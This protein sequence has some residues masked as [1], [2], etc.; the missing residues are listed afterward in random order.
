MKKYIFFALQTKI[1]FTFVTKNY[2]E[3]M[4]TISNVKYNNAIFMKSI[5]RKIS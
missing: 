3:T 2:D 5:L 1:I 4:K